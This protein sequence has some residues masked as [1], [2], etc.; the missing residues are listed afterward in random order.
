M[1]AGAAFALLGATLASPIVVAQ[2]NEG[3]SGVASKPQAEARVQETA[4]RAALADAILTARQTA[5]GRAFGATLRSSLKQRLVLL[6]TDDLEAFLNAGG[7]GNIEAALENRGIPN[8][9]SNPRGDMVYTALTPCRIVDTRS[10]GSGPLRAGERRLYFANGGVSQ[11]GAPDCGVPFLAAAVEMNFVAV[12]PSGPGDLRAVDYSPAN[13]VAPFPNASVL[14]YSNLSGLNIANGIAQPICNSA[15][16][17]C[18]SD[19]LVLA[20]ASDTDLVIDVVGYFQPLTKSFV[21]T[22]QTTTTTTLPLTPGCVN[23]SGG[24]ITVVAP[25]AGTV[26]VRANVGLFLNH[27][28]GAQDFARVVLATTNDDCAA[29]GGLGFATQ[30]VNSQLPTAGYREQL[31]LSRTFDVPAG[32]TTFYL[33]G[34]KA[35]GGGTHDLTF[36]GLDATFLPN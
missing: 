32:S 18:N 35:A 7:L 20:D 10:G 5:S 16:T 30:E 27:T 14:N 34:Q 9:V 24:S 25:V 2:V 26:T 19:L 36:A 8:A 17:I 6:P 1:K 12:G 4:R 22:G 23:A 11:G 3:G 13:L 31:G 15:T 33:N 21:V 28:F 29:S